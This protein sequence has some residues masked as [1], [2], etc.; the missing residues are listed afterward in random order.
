MVNG[1]STNTGIITTVK[2]D[3]TGDGIL[4]TISLVGVFT[5]DSIYLR[6]ITLSVQDGMTGAIRNVPLRVD[7]GFGPTITLFDF[8]GNGVPDILI[9]I[10]SGGSGGIIFYYVYSFM[11]FM[12]R[13]MFDFEEYDEKY[14]YT[15]IYLDYY[16]VEVTSLYNNERYLI[17]ISNRGIDYLSEIY[18]EAGRLKEPIEGFVDPL[19]GLF[20][21]DFES[22]GK[23][24]LFGFQGISGRYHADRLGYINNTL[25]WRNGEFKL[26]RQQVAIFGT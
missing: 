19:S 8:M 16:K 25:S 13:L 24:E 18:D 26:T 20:P 12:P 6:N 14:K 11:N 17:D 22:D 21:I 4:D 5:Q 3:V 23:Y 1:F 15:V 2:G 10:A 9:S 7:S